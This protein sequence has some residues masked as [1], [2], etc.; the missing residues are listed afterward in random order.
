MKTMSDK[1]PELFQ[2]LGGI[3]PRESFN[4]EELAGMSPER[5]VVFDALYAA[6]EGEQRAEKNHAAAQTAVKAALGEADRA[7]TALYKFAPKLTAHDL[8]RR[9][10]KHEVI[11]FEPDPETAA[12]IKEAEIT[13]KTAEENL[14]HARNAAGAAA[15]AIKPSRGRVAT[16]L[17]SYLARY[18]VKTGV[19]AVK[20]VIETG[21]KQRQ[22]NRDAGRPA[23]VNAPQ[24]WQPQSVL[25]A[26]RHNARGSAGFSQA[27][28][29]RPGSFPASQRGRKLPSEK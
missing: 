5:R 22:A 9:D 11:P 24:P 19:A 1:A 27:V 28:G 29:A 10:V 14:E 17:Q 4:A 8:W 16:A 25:D 3:R 7:R 21:Q 13:L 12:K 23:N 6:V 26:V 15:M 20:A 2:P 18:P